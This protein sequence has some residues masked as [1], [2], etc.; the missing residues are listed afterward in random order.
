MVIAV[1]GEEHFKDLPGC[2]LLHEA[3][4]LRADIGVPVAAIA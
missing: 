3:L 4:G 1:I 2:N